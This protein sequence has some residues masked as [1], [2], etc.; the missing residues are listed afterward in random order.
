MLFYYPVRNSRAAV[1]EALYAQNWKCQW[2]S[3]LAPGAGRRCVRAPLSRL[4]PV[5]LP[6][7]S[8]ATKSTW[9]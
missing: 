5:H 3:K 1:L 9:T 6:P 4:V 7:P 8:E 2:Q